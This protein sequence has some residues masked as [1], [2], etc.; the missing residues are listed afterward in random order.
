[1]NQLGCIGLVRLSA[2]GPISHIQIDATPPATATTDEFHLRRVHT[3]HVH[4]AVCDYR[5]DSIGL[6][7][8]LFRREHSQKRQ[9]I[10]DKSP[11]LLGAARHSRS[12]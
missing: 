12:L 4:P 9:T 8:N 2:F 3:S 11:F 7:C 10:L 1:L 5:S 6:V